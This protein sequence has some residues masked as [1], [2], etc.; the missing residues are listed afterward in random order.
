MLRTI[1]TFGEGRF[2]MS[3]AVSIHDNLEAG[4]LNKIAKDRC[5]P[6]NAAGATKS[7]AWKLA[8]SAIQ[9]FCIIAV[10]SF[11]ANFAYA[12]ETSGAIVGI[13]VDPSGAIVPGATVDVT[14]IGTGA[15]RTT[16]TDQRGNYTVSNLPLGAYKVAVNAKGF[17]PAVQSPVTIQ[18]KSRVRADFNLAL[19]SATTVVKVSGAR[20][21]LQTDTAE[22]GG[23]IGREDLQSLP[24]ISRNFLTLAT[25]VPGTTP[26]VPGDRRAAFNGAAITISGSSSESNNVIIDGVSDNEYFTGAM[27]VLPPMD[28]IQEFKVQTAQYSTE[29]GSSTGGIINIAIKSG[30]NNFHGFAYEYLQKDA[31]DAQGYFDVKKTPFSSNI[32]GGGVGGPVIKD[33]VFFFGD[34]QGI[35]T[36]SPSQLLTI[37]PTALEK[38]GDFSQSGY[39]IYDPST[40]HPDPNNPSVLVRDPFPGNKIPTSE[41]NPISAGLLSYY[42]LPNF[43][44]AGVDANYRAVLSKT[45]DFNSYDIRIDDDITPADIFTGRVSRQA[46]TVGQGG[47]LSDHRLD[48]SGS[49]DG[50]NVS[51]GYTHIFN[52]KL[53]N[54][55]HIGYNYSHYGND[56]DVKKDVLGPFNIPNLG[57]NPSAA[58]FPQI[59][60]TNLAGTGVSR[61]VATIPNPFVLVENT[62]QAVDNATYEKGPH[63]MQFGFEAYRLSLRDFSALPGSYYAGF[64]GAYT[65]PYV[66]KS[67]PNGLADAILGLS[68]GVVTQYKFDKT[69]LFS[70]RFGTYIQDYWRALPKLTVSMGLRWQV[71]TP[72][73]ELHDRITNFSLSSG[74]FLLP[75]STEPIINKLIGPLPPVFSYVPSDQ[76]YA[77]TNWADFAPR[78][79][80]SYSITD[81]IVAR[82]GV[83]L[84]Y[85]E[86]PSNVY[87]N[88]AGAPYSVNLVVLGSL[89]TPVNI[90]AGFPAG[91]VQGALAAPGL[92]GYYTPLHAHTPY[93]E[94][95]NGDIQ[96]SPTNST[97]LDIGYQ[98]QRSLHNMYLSYYN[99]PT[100]GPGAINPR[101]PFPK[102]GAVL[103]YVPIND[104]KFNALEILLQQNVY[105]GLTFGSAYTYGRC[106]AYSYGLDGGIISDP[107]NIQY[108]WGPCD[109]AAHHMWNS[110]FVY[111]VPNFDG[112]SKIGRA[113]LSNWQTSGILTVRSGRPFTVTLSPDIL[114]IGVGTNR[115]N[116]IGN[117]SGPRSIAQWFNT[118]AFALPTLYTFG[119]EAKNTL[120]GPSY[121]DLDFSVQRAFPVSGSKRFLL[122]MEAGNI[123][124]HPNFGLPTATYLG[125]NFGRIRST[126]G[127][128]RTM[129]AVFR[130]EF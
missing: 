24:V 99:I 56:L 3:K 61:P 97:V 46:G 72:W 22:T 23:L 60:I 106:Y 80:L 48:A 26:S 119:N 118:N 125:S 90:S 54:V 36:N 21:L 103:G 30:T 109:Y 76:V 113:I 29:F 105:R 95:W 7:S 58:G 17:Q 28:A 114:N 104:S 87:G 68:S 85:G 101:R 81:R 33:K 57:V 88:A 71:N 111:A 15:L 47:F 35:R 5:L 69:Y 8:S 27:A 122:R 44:Q 18:I 59:G 31:M 70:N 130:F 1:N 121:V 10:F 74:E 129:Q 34:Y 39:T 12:Q 45:N 50:L 9:I 49:E 89:Q 79:G 102:V 2:F 123:F 4:R 64:G 63:S 73:H 126:E 13:V 110:S 38:Q 98:G 92:G 112:T 116:V 43:S 117:T 82:A 65:G 78:F 120:R 37:V 94:K 32:F 93:A 83:G 51:L 62:F 19:G 40:T 115:P 11:A 55:A 53:V 86:V 67:E 91:G 124:N 42:P 77:H 108:D 14:S 66:G 128:P 107:F 20:Q 25:L 96:W 100:P 52:P 75:E 41:I 84:Y 16:V 6:R 127:N